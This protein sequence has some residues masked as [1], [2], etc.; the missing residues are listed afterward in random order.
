[1]LRNFADCMRAGNLWLV[2]VGHSWS[3]YRITTEDTDAAL[4]AIRADFPVAAEFQIVRE[5]KDAAELSCYACIHHDEKFVVTKL[6][7]PPPESGH[8]FVFGLRGLGA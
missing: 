8:E 1:M 5:I 7:R 6:T 2:H 4:E 3:V